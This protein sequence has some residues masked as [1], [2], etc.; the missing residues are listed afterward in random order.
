MENNYS[1]PELEC[2]DPA[3]S[4]RG[5]PCGCYCGGYEC[6]ECGLH[7]TPDSWARMLGAKLAWQ[8]A[9]QPSKS[10]R[11]FSR[12]HGCGDNSCVLGSPGGMATNGGCRCIPSSASNITSDE[13]QR[14]RRVVRAMSKELHILWRKKDDLA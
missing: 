7:L 12:K 1:P 5:Q 3:C 14:L 9:Q 11:E 6:D 10:Q 4:G 2:P 13:W 8:R